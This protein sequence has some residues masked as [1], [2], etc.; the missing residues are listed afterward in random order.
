MEP[1]K[2]IIKGARQH[3]LKNL[4][5]EIPKRKLVVLTG[6]SGS[7]KSSLAFDTLFA[8]GQRRYVESLSAYARQFLGQLDKPDYDYIRGLSPT[9]SIEQKAASN[10][11]RSTVGTI[12]EIYD[13]LRV[14]WARVGKQTCTGCGR[15]VGRMDSATIVKTL[16][17]L[18]PDTRFLLLAPIVQNRKGEFRDLFDQLR[19][20]GYSR[21]RLDGELV[22]LA[23]L[24][25]IPKQVRHTIDV[26]VDRLVMGPSV[27][28]RLTDSVETALKVG[29]GRCSIS[30]QT[31]EGFQPD[32]LFSERLGCDLCGLSFPELTPQS[33]S[34]NSPLGM[35]TRCNGL[36]T[37]LAMDP[38]KVIDPDL[39]LEE[40]AITVWNRRFSRAQRLNWRIVKAL[41]EG[42]GETLQTPYRDLPE[43]LKQLLLY[44][45]EGE[46]F[47][48]TLDGRKRSATLAFEG[49]LP[50]LMR[51]FKEAENEAYREY[52]A[53]YLSE[54]PCDLCQGSR[55]RAESR[56]V[57]VGG[58]TV[59]EVNR[60]TV[61]ECYQFFSN[62]TLPG[63]DA[64]IA[65]EL[66]KEISNRLKFLN[67][68][69][70]NYLTLDRSGPSLSGGE[71]QRI[72]LASQLGSELTG[73]L[74]ILDEPSIG[75]HQRDNRRL[76]A[77]LKHLRDLGN[78]VIVVEHDRETMEESDWII[79][80]G[81]GA[82]LQGGY[83]VATGGPDAIRSAPGSL[84]GRYLRN[85]LAIQIP[86]RRRPPRRGHLVVRGARA[87]NLKGI[88]VPFPVG[89]FT[90]VTGVS[91]AGK[92]SLVNE[93]LYPALARHL[94]QSNLTVGEHSHID[95]LEVIDKVIDID[96]SPIGRT[97]R[98]NPAT[99]TKVFDHIRSL[100]ARLPESHMYGFQPGRFSFNVKGGRCE[101]CEG[102]G[103]RRI[104]M[105]FLPDVYVTCEQCGGKRFNDA[106]LRVKYRGH[107]IADILNLAVE[108]AGELFQ[109]HRAIQ[110]ILR[111]LL[112]VGL[113]YLQL[114]QPSP[115]LS[116]GEAQ[117]IKLS[118]ELAKVATGDTLYIL[119]EPSTGLHFDDIQK[120]LAVIQTLT[121]AG[122]TVIMIEHNLDIIKTADFLVDLGPEG[123]GA[124]GEIVVMGTPE[125]VADHPTSHTGRYLRDLL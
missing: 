52:F 43:S 94:Y 65:V 24:D 55:L 78:T 1:D 23:E 121:D 37:A 122:N 17:Q 57:L 64:L 68:V 50:Y 91:G 25:R 30:I 29:D 47:E 58:K 89:L 19:K 39:S 115:T 48:L 111:T 106:T 41:V 62:L 93:T 15:P 34:F 69:G 74:Y 5:L 100:F 95:G 18:A 124:G 108:Q 96:Q 45:S 46:L 97:P 80:F 112:D 7:G 104:E 82:G 73:V 4:Y 79:D 28:A 59:V 21:I 90:C 113:G 44:G 85:E 72:R 81:P 49:V 70:L 77:T 6:P 36:G 13:Y 99:Y 9:I 53:G 75:L 22:D 86:P 60:S 38:D 125:Q 87:N 35:C 14:L 76:L 61:Q 107:S 117:R 8:E 102:A 105:H 109:T 66:L 63:N 118:R 32:Q 92:S 120:L 110:R 33:F 56:A 114:G 31:R 27:E 116:G 12:T 40:G 16:M 51:R 67:D 84:T 71:A 123:G 101:A 10:N 98:S 26:V 2:I 3:N 42:Y 11:P 83:V 54:A 20:E 88:D 119:D 103:V